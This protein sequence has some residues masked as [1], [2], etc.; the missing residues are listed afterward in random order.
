MKLLAIFGASGHGK[1]VADTAQQCGWEPIH[2]YDDTWPTQQHIEN[3]SI[4]GDTATLLQQG[5]R[6]TGILVAIGDNQ[7]RLHKTRQIQH[8][9]HPLATLKHPT[10]YLAAS[11]N[12]GDGSIVC[13]G[14]IIQ[15][16]T[17]IGVAS[18]I[19]TSAS[20]DHDCHLANGVHISPGAHL[21]GNIIVGENSW[22]GIGASIK[23]NLTIGAG[24]AVITDIPDNT[25]AA[26]VPARPI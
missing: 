24:S 17:T 14:A 4:V 10:A 18:I 3:R 25:C 7:A 9:Q 21:A 19:N 15:P 12:L 6:Y 1:V 22:I 8:A 20:I 11:A 13:A 16:G 5:H 2:H 23:H 26:G